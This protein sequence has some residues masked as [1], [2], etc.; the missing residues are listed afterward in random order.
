MC[1]VTFVC[2]LTLFMLLLMLNIILLLCSIFVEYGSFY[3]IQ[4]STLWGVVVGLVVLCPMPGL[5]MLW[6]GY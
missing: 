5:D 2:I 3:L 6:P 1:S 4:F